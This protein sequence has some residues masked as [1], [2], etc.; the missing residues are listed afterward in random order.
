MSGEATIVS[1][2]ARALETSWSG[3]TAGRVTVRVPATSANVGVGFDCLG[4]A[5]DL[6]AT[7]TF[8]ATEGAADVITGCEERFRGSD[9]LALRS[10]RHACAELGLPTHTV[11]LDIDSPI[12]LSGGL[13]SSSACVVAGV[14]AA[15]ILGGM[16]YDR[17]RTLDLAVAMEGHPDNVAP[18]VLGG[19]TSSFVDEDGTTTTLRDDVA[20]HLR[21]VTITPPYE[22]RTEQA[23]EILPRE[24]PRST[25][26]WQM[27]RCVAVIRALRRGNA[28]LLAKACHDRLHEPYRSKLIPHY[29]PVK[30]ACLEAGAAAFVISGSG[31]TMLAMCADDRSARAVVEAARKVD[32]VLEVRML[33]PNATGATLSV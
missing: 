15:Q 26:V 20:P 8:E 28:E 27:G 17:R 2:G 30:K 33:G 31:S 19:L 11:R 23:R 21:F 22:I 9:N 10:Y 4:L 24:V 6:M 14:C 12:P 7:F 16:A 5:L 18:A 3:P 32:A 25:A 1:G 13:G 29:E